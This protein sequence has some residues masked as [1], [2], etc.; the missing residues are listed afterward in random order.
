MAAIKKEDIVTYYFSSD[1]GTT[2]EQAIDIII[3]KHQETHNHF[4]TLTDKQKKNLICH[5]NDK[6]KKCHHVKQYFLSKHRKWLNGDIKLVGENIDGSEHEATR[7][8]ESTR[9]SCSDLNISA[10]GRPAIPFGEASESTKRRKTRHLRSQF[11]TEELAYATNMRLRQEGKVDAAKLC[12][13]ATSSPTKAATILKKANQTNECIFSPAEALNIIVNTDMSKNSYVFLR[14]A[15]RQKQCFMYPSYEKVLHEKLKCYPEGVNVTQFEATVP[16]QSL[17]SHTAQRLIVAQQNA[18]DICMANCTSTNTEQIQHTLQLEMLTKY[19]IDGSGNQSLYSIKFDQELHSNINETSIVSSF[20]CPV[21]LSLIDTNKIVWQNPSPSSP[22]YC[23]PIKLKFIKESPELVRQEISEIQ[24]AIVNLFP[25]E[26]DNIKVHHKLILTM[27]DGKVCQALTNTPSASSCY[28][29]K[30]RT[31]PS[32]MNNLRGIEDKEIDD[33]ALSYGISPLHLL[34]N[35]MECILHIGYR[36]KLQTWMVKGN[37]N[38]KIYNE[39]KKRICHE[40]KTELGLNVD[41]PAQGTGTTNNGNT[42]RRFFA[43]PENVSRITGVDGRLI[44][45]LSVILCALNSG[46]DIISTA[47]DDYAKNTANLFVQLYNWYYMPVSMHKMLMHGSQVI[48]SLCMSVGHASEE[49]IEGTHKILR[50]AREHHTC[51]RSRVRSNT[52][53][54]N[55]L[56]LI[57]DPVLAG[58]RKKSAHTLKQLPSEVLQLLKSPEV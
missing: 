37:E 34:I 11:S 9:P 51:K 8:N 22:F 38:K 5:F 57:S 24:E 53:L 23:R 36:L 58:F 21:R 46:Y 48:E 30:P 19:G 55:W 33:N 47:F 31:N 42:A 45:Q 25:T 54:I 16:L 39:E 2:F 20:I 15:H 17:L 10:R 1:K 12:T 52:D 29:C 32:A 28:I 40:L 3:K 35:S 49:G 7:L 4:K 56:L 18:I 14:E 13:E 27:V 50:S 26:V 41:C 6:W 44:H 43:D